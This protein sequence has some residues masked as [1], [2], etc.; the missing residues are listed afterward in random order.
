MKRK[1]LLILFI[2]CLMVWP[3][4]VQ[5]DFTTDSNAIEKAAQSVLMLACSN[6]DGSISTGSGFVAFNSQTLVTNCHV[7]DEAKEIVASDD[8]GN[9]YVIDRVY[10]VSEH[11]DIAILGF[12]TPTALKP[13]PLSTGDDLQ[14]GQPVVTIGSPEGLKNT[15]STGVVSSLAEY[16]G[17]PEI[18]ISAPISHGSSGGALFDANGHVVGVTSSGLAEGQNL[19]FAVRSSVPLA[20]YAA[21]K[22]ET[23][24]FNNWPKESPMDFT[25]GEKLAASTA[26]AAAQVQGDWLC[27]QCGQMNSHNFCQ[28]CGAAKP[29]WQCACGQHNVAKFCGNCGKNQETLLIDLNA[30]LTLM[31]DQKY[32]EAVAALEQLGDYNCGGI[33]SQAGLNV[34][35]A[36][37]LRACYYQWGLQLEAA[38][39]YAAAS[40]KYMASGAYADAPQRILEMAYLDAGKA[41]EKGEYLYAA[42]LYLAL[43]DYKDSVDMAMESSYQMGL[44]FLANGEYEAAQEIFLLMPDYKEAAEQEKACRYGMAEQALEN[45]ELEA[46]FDKFIELGDYK[47]AAERILETYYKKGIYLAAEGDYSNAIAAFE[48]AEDFD[49]AS[50]QI[51][52]AHY[53]MGI[54]HFESGNYQA[55]ID[56]L[57]LAGS[58]ENASEKLDEVYKARIK[59]FIDSD[60]FTNAFA[61]YQGALSKGHNVEDPVLLEVNRSSKETAS[62]LKLASSM[63]FLDIPRGEDIFLQEYLP[64]IITMEQTL[65][66]NP[67]GIIYLSEYDLISQTIYP[68]LVRYSTKNDKIFHILS[69]LGYLSLESSG[70]K[71]YTA[72]H[73]IDVKKAEEALGLTADGIITVSEQEVILSQ[74]VDPPQA[75]K[76]LKVSTKKKNGV[77][78]ATLSWP[79]VKDAAYYSI[80]RNGQFYGKTADTKFS[81]T[82]YS[83]YDK[84]TFSVLAEKYTVSA[85]KFSP[86]KQ[87]KGR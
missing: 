35:A 20:L 45:G 31:A 24:T 15:V 38:Q 86:A 14:R 5:A 63:G 39:E 18:Q 67:D 7:M 82:I 60:D 19:N 73:A 87:V 68:G 77:T 40:E 11:M 9:L 2:I 75:V 62:I 47:D 32:E 43:G 56:E 22:G 46:A 28:Y 57:S 16:G 59:S 48:L 64:A 51:Q 8:N 79:K 27:P 3:L 81:F 49:D 26:P 25:A 78:V 50:Y 36:D 66:L 30:A 44:V 23:Y 1:G 42:E 65:G 72:N 29:Q 33:A 10:C 61:F 4:G 21:W 6:K 12:S 85:E 71:A 34:S 76:S 70:W 55:A 69:D 54:V 84:W 41:F 17:V 83:S 53:D 37:Q 52:K 74:R 58:Y 13:L 80:Y